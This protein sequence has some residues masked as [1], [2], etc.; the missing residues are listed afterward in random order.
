MDEADRK[1]VDIYE[2]LESTLLIL[3]YR[4][5]TQIERSEY[6][7]GR[8][9]GDLPLVECFVGR[10]N[11]VFMNILVNS[12]DAYQLITEKHNGKI[13]CFSNEGV[14]PEFVIELPIQISASE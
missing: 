4:L 1:S 8:D 14:G 11:Q 13:E 10:L 6:R 12:I 9:F 2:G 7:V 3:A 5:K